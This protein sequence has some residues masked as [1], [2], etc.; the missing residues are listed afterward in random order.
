MPTAGDENVIEEITVNGTT[1]P[2]VDKVATI[3][4]TVSSVTVN[5]SNYT[6]D[7]N[8]LVNL[9]TISGESGSGGEYNV[10]EGVT[11]NGN[12]APITNKIAAITY[13]APT[14]AKGTTTG[15]GNAV[16][17]ISVSGHTIT[18]TKGTTFLT[19]YTET[20]PTVPAAVKAIT[21]TDISNWNNK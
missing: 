19:S 3:T 2:V 10:I 13:T 12:T 8:G 16:T 6:P 15:S 1:V 5:G 18:L 7:A 21:A 9:G 20:D 14:L 17:D 11:F 4:G